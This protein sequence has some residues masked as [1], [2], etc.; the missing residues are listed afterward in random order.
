MTRHP[1]LRRTA[2]S[3]TGTSRTSRTCTSS[4]IV[5][6]LRAARAATAECGPIA[7]WDVSAIT[8]MSYVFYGLNNFDAD[9]SNWDTSSVTN[10]YNMFYVRS[11]PCPAPNPQSSPPLHT[12]CPA[13]AFRLPPPS[14]H[15]AAHRMP[16]FRLSAGRVGVQPAAE[17]RH[18]QR[19]EHGPDVLGALLPVPCPQSA[20]GPSPCMLRA[21][22]SP[23]ASRLPART[24]RPASYAPRSTLGSARRRSTSR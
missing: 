13:V 24:P 21:S 15:L 16:S 17:L 3:P 19:H 1:P 9:V 4:S 10:M 14:P 18:L 23:A 5:G 11:S 7:E 12:A 6:P 8:E 2:P 20:V 22:R